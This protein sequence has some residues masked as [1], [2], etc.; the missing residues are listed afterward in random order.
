MRPGAGFPALGSNFSGELMQSAHAGRVRTVIEDIA[1]AG[2]ALAAQYFVALH[3]MAVVRFDGNGGRR[4][5]RGRASN[6][7]W[8]R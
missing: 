8:F 5:R 7:W 6:D 4:V 1:E 3:E 2:V